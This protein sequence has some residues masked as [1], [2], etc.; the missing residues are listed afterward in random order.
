[1]TMKKINHKKKQ[2]GASTTIFFALSLPAILTMTLL[3][4]QVAKNK[5][6]QSLVDD[7]ANML[8]RPILMHQFIYRNC[9]ECE[10][11]Q[12]TFVKNI[13]SDA[14][15]LEQLGSPTSTTFFMSFGKLINTDGNPPKFEAI[16]IQDPN[17]ATDVFNAVAIKIVV[18]YTDSIVISSMKIP[19]YTAI[20]T[21]TAA[22]NPSSV[23]DDTKLPD[24]CCNAGIDV[25]KGIFGIFATGMNAMISVA[26]SA[27]T[28]MCGMMNFGCQMTTGAGTAMCDLMGGMADQA[29]DAGSDITNTIATG[30]I[31]ATLSSGSDD[32]IKA[33]NMLKDVS[34]TLNDSAE[35]AM[36]TGFGMMNGMCQGMG[37]MMG[38]MCN[39]MDDMCEEA[40]CTMKNMASGMVNMMYT[41]ATFNMTESL[42]DVVENMTCMAKTMVSMPVTM[43]DGGWDAVEESATSTVN[44]IT[45]IHLN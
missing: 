20:G 36:D 26:S 9:D 14:K 17:P 6:Q 12:E 3:S 24:S 31:D 42:G 41:M 18:E 32:Q 7:I 5:V 2:L 34:T 19:G 21:A 44:A 23:P 27:M 15:M 13:I 29:T 4:T 33:A 35:F 45:T 28:G 1:M 11:D 40:S 39:T 25:Q 22:I 43:W 30:I 37:T 10:Q 8:A 38:G 16:G